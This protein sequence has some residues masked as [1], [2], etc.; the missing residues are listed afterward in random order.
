[1]MTLSLMP[2]ND[3]FGNDDVTD[4]KMIELKMMLSS[5]MQKNDLINDDDI[6]DAKK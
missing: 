3:Q 1:M 4:S 5:M 2:K 6:T